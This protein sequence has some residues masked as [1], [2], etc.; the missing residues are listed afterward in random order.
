VRELR[1]LL[2]FFQQLHDGIGETRVIDDEEM[3][4]TD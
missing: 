4:A 3:L 1:P 2:T